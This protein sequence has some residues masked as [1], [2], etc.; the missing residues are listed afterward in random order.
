MRRP[1]SGG[2][3]SD[4]ARYARAWRLAIRAIKWAWQI[5]LDFCSRMLYPT[6]DGS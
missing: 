6:L 4:K 5:S 2:M 1:V 3:R